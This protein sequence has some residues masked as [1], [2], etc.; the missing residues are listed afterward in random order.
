VTGDAGSILARVNDRSRRDTR[1]EVPIAKR[2]SR[3]PSATGIPS[4]IDDDIDE[5]A[6]LAAKL[7]SAEQAKKRAE[8]REREALARA[9]VAEQRTTEVAATAT[10][11]ELARRLAE[12]GL[13]LT[14]REAAAQ[15][16]LD[17]LRA[18]R[19]EVSSLGELARRLIG[20]SAAQLPA[21]ASTEPAGPRTQKLTARTLPGTRRQR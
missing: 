13:R 4:P 12:I 6:T 21:V 17:D 8:E 20:P 11:S 10:V 15:R 14:A 18:L 3:R 16:E 5:L 2:L 19:G 7:I 9:H 1:G